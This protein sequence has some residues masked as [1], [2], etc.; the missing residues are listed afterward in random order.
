[1]TKGNAK[2]LVKFDDKEKIIDIVSFVS[3]EVP[4]VGGPVSFLF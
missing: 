2:S 1:M 4:W 3:S